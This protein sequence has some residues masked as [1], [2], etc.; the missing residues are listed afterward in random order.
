[1]FRYV[2]SGPYPQRL[3]QQPP[4]S[5]VVGLVRSTGHLD[6]VSALTYSEPIGIVNRGGSHSHP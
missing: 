5:K 3:A 1:M 4:L 2:S 6:V